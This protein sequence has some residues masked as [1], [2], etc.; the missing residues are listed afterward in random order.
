M[1]DAQMDRMLDRFFGPDT[2]EEQAKEKRRRARIAAAERPSALA[3]L[4]A[5]SAR[6]EQHHAA[7]GRRG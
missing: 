3:Q 7:M 2:P 1:N 4:A 5:E 6:I